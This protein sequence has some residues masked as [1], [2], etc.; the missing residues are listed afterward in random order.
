M[1]AL[2][3]FLLAKLED[4]LVAPTRQVVESTRLIRRGVGSGCGGR[5][6]NT[7]RGAAGV[8]PAGLC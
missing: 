7:A 2:R 4:N 3:A 8:Q 1:S 5:R 6:G